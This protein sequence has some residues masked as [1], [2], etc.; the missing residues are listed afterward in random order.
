M[1]EAEV[2]QRLAQDLSQ[3]GW[4]ILAMMMVVTLVLLV[5]VSAQSARL[6]S[7]MEALQVEARKR[8]AGSQPR[9]TAY[10]PK[11]IISEQLGKSGRKTK[12]GRRKPVY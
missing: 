2:A 5:L 9:R 8:A 3:Q 11:K 10:E 4:L 1:T 6:A 12:P 7:L